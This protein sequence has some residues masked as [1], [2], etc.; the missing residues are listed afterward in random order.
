MLSVFYKNDKLKPY[1]KKISIDETEQD[2]NLEE[3][4]SLSD[5]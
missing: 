5:E 3:F 1:F 2:L 4:E